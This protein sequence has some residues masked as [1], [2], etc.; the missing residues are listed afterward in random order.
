[1]PRYVRRM[2][3][4]APELKLLALGGLGLYFLLAYRVALGTLGV[5]ELPAGTPNL[6]AVTWLGRWKMFTDLRAE[7]WDLVAEVEVGGA[8]RAVDLGARYPSHWDE[9][10][11]YLRDDYYRDARRLGELARDL[12]TV[13][14]ATAARFTEQRW[15]KSRGQLDQPRA[16][17]RTTTLGSFPCR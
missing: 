11:G 4:R 13:D 6:L 17:V 12:C 3:E 5:A 16:D 1:M 15:A 7:H 9:G 2:T 14:G 10:P 8:W